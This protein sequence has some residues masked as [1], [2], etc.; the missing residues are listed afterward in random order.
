MGKASNKGDK[1]K[2]ARERARQHKAELE[3]KKYQTRID[4]VKAKYDK[5][6]DGL[7]AAKQYVDDLREIILYQRDVDNPQ[8]P[9]EITFAERKRTLSQKEMIEY[10][11]KNNANLQLYLEAGAESNHPDVSVVAAGEV[12]NQTITST[13]DA[14][15]VLQMF[16]SG[17]LKDSDLERVAILVAD[18]YNELNIGAVIS[19][20]VDQRLRMDNGDIVA[21]GYRTAITTKEH[22]QKSGALDE[23][24][25]LLFS[26]VMSEYAERYVQSIETDE[27]DLAKEEYLA[28]SMIEYTGDPKKKSAIPG[29]QLR[30]I[31]ETV[32]KRVRNKE[33]KTYAES[34]LIDLPSGRLIEILSDK[35]N[36]HHEDA[37]RI[38]RKRIL[39][40]SGNKTDALKYTDT[41]YTAL[42]AN[43]WSQNEAAELVGYIIGSLFTTEE[44]NDLT[45]ED[46]PT[47]LSPLT[48]IHHRDKD[49]QPHLNMVVTYP[50]AEVAHPI[51]L[52]EYQD[53]DEETSRLLSR[54]T[55]QM[56]KDVIKSGSIGL[57]KV[58][59]QPVDERYQL[60]IYPN[61]RGKRP[62][63]SYALLADQCCTKFLEIDESGK[64]IRPNKGS[65]GLAA[66]AITIAA[67]YDQLVRKLHVKEAVSKPNGNQN[68]EKPDLPT[69]EDDQP[70]EEK[71]Q[72][73]RASQIQILKD[74]IIIGPDV[75]E[76]DE[77]SELAVAEN[78][79]TGEVEIL[80]IVRPHWRE[81][82]PAL[83]SSSRLAAV[84]DVFE[85]PKSRYFH[86]RAARLSVIAKEKLEQIIEG[87]NAQLFDLERIIEEGMQLPL[88]QEILEN[89]KAAEMHH[90]ERLF[91][92]LS[93]NDAVDTDELSRQIQGKDVGEQ[94][95]IINKALQTARS[96]EGREA[97][98]VTGVPLKMA[99]P[100]NVVQ[101]KHDAETN[102]AAFKE[103]LKAKGFTVDISLQR[104]GKRARPSQS[105]V[106][107]HVRGTS[108][109]KMKG[110]VGKTKDGYTIVKANSTVEAIRRIIESGKK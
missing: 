76:L 70:E 106:P 77:S 51:F 93:G 88:D 15:Q 37:I 56:R 100:G 78:Q 33:H 29:L 85:N 24:E 4:S 8:H 28:D 16:K 68:L 6:K 71:T 3:K 63:A 32:T 66:E 36:P 45:G 48:T 27:P 38:A 20:H 41:L 47:A 44:L 52:K 79:E 107:P 109:T 81:L 18:I 90:Y 99:T 40:L 64:N 102:F 84:H 98:A 75:D 25:A 54:L 74:H 104:P 80:H 58:I 31:R 42:Q 1:R 65:T 95:E 53:I 12:L 94:I 10:L 62:P 57:R 87:Q 110:H 103:Q 19:R 59:A 61:N 39:T 60:T 69:T 21:S 82:S 22:A 7:T 2:E 91:N 30:R 5:Q 49:G 13:R 67:L 50:A 108:R 96:K 73:L 11:R 105:Y 72:E 55:E 9:S 35:E 23:S 101:E 17:E 97:Q 34:H 46:K 43:G 89:L 86:E 92:M 14:N 83:V 26:V